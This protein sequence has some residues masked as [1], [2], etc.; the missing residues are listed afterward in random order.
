MKMEMLSNNVPIVDCITGIDIK[1]QNSTIFMISQLLSG[2]GKKEK[3]DTVTTITGQ[4]RKKHSKRF[5]PAS[6][7]I[8]AKD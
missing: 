1:L 8:M 6:K 3:S 5:I 4:K 7:L 2:I